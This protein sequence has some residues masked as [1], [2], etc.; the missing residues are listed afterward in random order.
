MPESYKKTTILFPINE[1]GILLGMKKQGFGAGWWN[2]FGGKLEAGET[3][4]QAAV[5]ETFE[6]AN[7]RAHEL[8]HV[9]SLH[10]YFGGELG[11]VSK[12]YICRNFDG[13]PTETDEMRPQYFDLN[14]VP[15]DTMWPADGL[16]IPEALAATAPLG[17]IVHFKEDKGF[18]SIQ[19]VDVAPL[20]EKF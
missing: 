15:Y 11:V 14:D 9:A 2:G 20:E 5:R 7:I 10:F 13:T 12:A 1:S 3:Y 16:W 8:F 19:K 17:F 4:E 6:E 18:E